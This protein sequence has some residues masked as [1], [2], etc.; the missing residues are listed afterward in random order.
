MSGKVSVSLFVTVLGLTLCCSNSF[1]VA[2]ASADSVT[3][4]PNTKAGKQST[5]T[6]ET[7]GA[8]FASKVSQLISATK[9]QQ[10]PYQ[11]DEAILQA[12]D[13]NNYQ[14]NQIAL[15]QLSR[16][17]SYAPR[18]KYIPLAVLVLRNDL[19]S[20]LLL[21]YYDEESH[22]WLINYGTNGKFID[23]LEVYYDN[24]EGS[25]WKSAVIDKHKIDITVG[26]STQEDDEEK[27]TS[28]RINTEGR[29]VQ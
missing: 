23:A 15:L 27:I 29:F 20:L 8:A 24:S 12:A 4:K 19:K 25:T 28:F 3:A 9:T 2:P 26:E 10:L 14:S 16:L 21:Q 13:N 17:K 18:F 1:V 11:V 6:A 7:E 22:A 5:S